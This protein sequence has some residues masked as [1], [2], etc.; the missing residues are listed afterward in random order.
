MK[1][2][3]Q[4]IVRGAAIVSAFGLVGKALGVVQ[5]QI[6][7]FCFG[8][9]SDADAYV[10]AFQSIG[11][12]F[13]VIPQKAIAPFLPLF[14]EKREREGEVA[15]W[16]F[17]AG[18]GLLLAAVLGACVAAGVAAAPWLV[19]ATAS[20]DDEAVNAT[21]VSLVRTLLPC[22]LFLGLAS[23]AYLIL[24]A[25]KRFAL[26]AAGDLVNR[27]L[28]I[29][30]VLL[31]Y[32]RLGIAAMAAALI[33]GA[34]GCFLL[35]MWGIRV[36]QKA[37]LAGAPG[38]PGIRPALGDPAMRRLGALIPP[39][40]LGAVLAQIRTIF[41]F[42]FASEMGKGFVSSLSYAKVVPDTLT[43]LV[44]FAIGVSI[45]P[46]FAGL[47]AKRDADGLT[48]TLMRSLRLITLVFV[49]LTVGLLIARDPLLQIVFL[50]GRFG[51]DSL[52]L[53]AAPFG[54]YTLGLTSFAI[55]IILMQFYFAMKDTRTPMV[56]GI[57][58]L[59]GHVGFILATRAEM[60][61][62]SMALAATVSKTLKIAV[63]YALLRA[64]LPDLR[65]RAN[66]VFLAKCLAGAAV[67]AAVGL[68]VNAAVGPWTVGY[69]GMWRL[70]ALAAQV[71]VVTGA[72]VATYA[73]AC[74]VLRIPEARELA[75]RLRRRKGG[76]PNA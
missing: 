53:T 60:Q 30:V 51:A 57:L 29:A 9:G 74:H 72:C 58:A 3:G 36:L 73:A 68:A 13:V 25:H 64:K 22:A 45:Y 43:T 37:A 31:L 1:S 42:R 20:F 47:A 4:S 70:V 48:H 56:V 65:L 15:A 71:G 17:A 24:N 6:T 50:R 19:Q 59:L 16:S 26:P 7:A 2:A 49:P 76:R 12:A 5:K 75:D 34:A 10:L 69:R 54:W 38:R 52:A 46:V 41:D 61:H 8:T 63:M 44:P 14:M 55:E 33:A 32:H 35:Q 27:A 11:F 21:T 67:M 23:L 28:I 18:V 39:V 66:G 40:L 62:S